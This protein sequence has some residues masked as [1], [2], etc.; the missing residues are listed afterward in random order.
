[1]SLILL[2]SIRYQNTCIKD[3]ISSLKSDFPELNYV[4]PEFN[5]VLFGY[6]EKQENQNPVLE[7][8]KPLLNNKN[9][10]WKNKYIVL[11]KQTNIQLMH[12]LIYGWVKWVEIINSNKPEHSFEKQ[13]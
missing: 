13:E 2:T 11:E 8:W 4:F 7:I 5:S 3:E 9:N 6:H 10:I 1:M 12:S